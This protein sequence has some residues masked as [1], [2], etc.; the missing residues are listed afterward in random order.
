MPTESLVQFR[1]VALNPAPN[2]GMVR[3]QAAL[4]QQFLDIAERE[5]TPQIPTDRTQNEYGLGLPPLEDRRDRPPAPQGRRHNDRDRQ[6][7]RLGKTH[8]AQILLPTPRLRIRNMD[9]PIASV[10]NATGERTYRVEKQS[11]SRRT[12]PAARLAAFLLQT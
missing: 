3:F 10:K 2:G 6:N 4:N 1:A 12:A 7:Q 11:A 8:D 9:L 5:R